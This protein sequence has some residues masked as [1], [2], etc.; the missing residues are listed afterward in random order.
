MFM[1]EIKESYYQSKGQM[2]EDSGVYTFVKDALTA[3]KDYLDKGGTLSFV[4]SSEKTI[5]TSALQLMSDNV[6]TYLKTLG[7]TGHQSISFTGIA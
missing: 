1:N 7:A 2:K 6:D 4:K 3:T 5:F